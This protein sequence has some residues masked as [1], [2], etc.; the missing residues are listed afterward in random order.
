MDDMKNA[1]MS[2]KGENNPSSKLSKEQVVQI[3]SLKGRL[4]GPKLG[5]IYNVHSNTIYR[6]FN[7]ETWAGESL[8]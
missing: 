5:K 8:E 4:S 6:I 2:T 7:G 3:K 1:G